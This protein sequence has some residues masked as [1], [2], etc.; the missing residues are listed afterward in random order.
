MWSNY[1]AKWL[2]ARKLKWIRSPFRWIRFLFCRSF[3]FYDSAWRYA[4]SSVSWVGHS[5][6]STHMSYTVPMCARC[7]VI[8]V[9]I[10]KKKS[11]KLFRVTSFR[12]NFWRLAWWRFSFTEFNNST[13]S[14]SANRC[15]LKFA[16]H[17]L[18]LLFSVFSYLA[19]RTLSRALHRRTKKNNEPTKTLTIARATVTNKS[20]A[21]V[22]LV[23]QHRKKLATDWNAHTVWRQRENTMESTFKPKISQRSVRVL[24]K[25]GEK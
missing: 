17:E 15:E 22:L 2:R 12:A 16:S 23:F 24:W 7:W 10:D 11:P 6:S 3:Y 13:P 25:R 5:I 14:T 19:V 18:L 20:A 9:N 21:L 8:N 1:A 4:T